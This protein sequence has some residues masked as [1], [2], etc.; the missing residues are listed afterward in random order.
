MNCPECRHWRAWQDGAG[1]AI[2]DGDATQ[3]GGQCAGEGRVRSSCRD[4][5]AGEGAGERARMPA[6][7]RFKTWPL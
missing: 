7:G 5:V 2:T 4:E 6:G 3:T 1:F